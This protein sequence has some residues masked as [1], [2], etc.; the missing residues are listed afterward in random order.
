MIYGDRIRLRAVSHDDLALF[1]EWLNDPEVRDGISI[2]LPMSQTHEEQWFEA[3]LKRPQEEHPLMIEIKDQDTWVP[4]GNIAL[5]G[6]DWRSRNAEVGI[7]I[8]AKAYWNQGYGSEVMRLMLQHGFNT[9]NLNRI[10][11]RVFDWNIR[12]VR[13]YEKVGFVHEGCMRQ[14]QFHEGEYRDVLIMSVLRTEWA[15]A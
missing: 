14:A 9:L 8:G 13:A 1:V 7:M 12:A 2:F 10:F 5:F 15:A 3:M 4:V 6:I 11:L